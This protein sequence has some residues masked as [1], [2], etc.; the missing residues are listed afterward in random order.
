[1]TVPISDIVQQMRRSLALSDPDLDTSIGTTTRKII[2]AVGEVVSEGYVDKYLLDYVYDVDSKVGQ[3]LDDFVAVFGFNRLPAKRATGTVIFQRNS[4]ATSNVLI[5]VGTQ[6]ATD[7]T[8]PVIVGTIIP[9]IIPIGDTT[10]EIPAQAVVGGSTGNITAN[11]LTRWVTPLSGVSKPANPQ[12][13]TGGTDAESDD[14]LRLRFK[15]TSFRNLAGTAQMFLGVALDNQAV[16]HAN[17]LGASKRWREQIEIVG[18]TAV[19]TI[20]DAAYIYAGSSVFGADIDAGQIFAPD[21]QYTF[22]DTLP[23]TI[24]VVDTISIPDGV[25]DWEF[26]YVST[27]SRND[28]D[29]GITNRV[30]VYVNGEEPTEASTVVLFRTS[31]LFNAAG[32]DPLNHLNFERADGS[33]PQVGNYFVQYPLGPVTDPALSNTL[34]ISGIT[35]TQ[36]IDFWLVN[37]ITKEGGTSTSMSGIEFLS[38][39]NGATHVMPTD[40]SVIAVDYVFNAVPRDVSNALANWRLV[41]TDVKVH[42]AQ[43]VLLDL[44]LAIIFTPGF[45]AA[46][47]QPS[48]EDALSKFIAGIDFDSVVQVSDLLEVAHMVSGVD[49]VRFLTDAD[50]ATHYAI[51]RVNPLGAVLNTYDNGGT[52]KRAIDVLIGD[53]E[54]PYLNSVTVVSKAQNTFGSAG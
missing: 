28:P 46:S 17:V 47:V 2:D 26:E 31:K 12:A 10:I 29:H 5:P 39:A 50:D 37:D 14:Q 33:H 16:S 9:A 4:P 52:P 48:L 25:Y 20:T 19:S 15:R 45:T 35:Y 3:D 32:G 21:V 8:P 43:K 11:S 36:D 18:G 34:T 51:Q 40:L 44:Y 42:Q 7:D 41:T 54:L 38:T 1:M 53:D 6:L 23:P 24:T 30:D 27:A 49:A 22:A 13:F